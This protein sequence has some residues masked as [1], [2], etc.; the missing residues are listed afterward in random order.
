MMKKIFGF[1]LLALTMSLMSCSGDDSSEST[2]NNNNN[3][4]GTI[5]A[6]I[7]GEEW[8]GTVKSAT[9]LKVQSMGSQRFD[10]T[11]EGDGQRIQIACEAPYGVTMPLTSYTFEQEAA[12]NALFSNSYL[13][14]SN[15]YMVHFPESGEVSITS[16]NDSN[17]KASGTF[18]FTNYKVGDIEGMSV[19][20][21]YV[22]TNGEFHNVVYTVY[23][24]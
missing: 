8:E 20:E 1:G 24:Q 2:N 10:I 6:V 14:G 21:N 17:K 19:P 7:N 5:T 15:S 11:A 4:Q 13:V 18:E 3:G 12:G 9:L 23:A 22:V 16:F